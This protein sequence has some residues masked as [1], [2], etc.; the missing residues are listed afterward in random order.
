VQLLE[1]DSIIMLYEFWLNTTLNSKI[2]VE[3][4]EDWAE[5]RDVV[6]ALHALLATCFHTGFFFSLFFNPEDGGDMS[7]Q[8]VS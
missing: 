8:N 5:I 1:E 6:R 2:S 4:D 7:L 3:S